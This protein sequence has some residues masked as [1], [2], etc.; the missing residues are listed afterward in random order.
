M[1]FI[2]VLMVFMMIEQRNSA[3]YDATVAVVLD[4]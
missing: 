1:G 4:R 2:I 3:Q